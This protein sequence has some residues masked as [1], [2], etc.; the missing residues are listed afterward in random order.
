MKT[1]GKIIFWFLIFI[2]LIQFIPVDRENKP[3]KKSE[4]FVDVFHTPPKVLQ[5][6]KNACYDCHSNE[7]VYPYYAFIAPISW[8]IKHHINEGRERLN[9]SVWTT[10]NADL[11]KNMLVNSADVLQ[12]KLMPMPGY[13]AY[14]PKANL[15]NAQRTVLINYFNKIL[16][17]KKY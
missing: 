16:E 12:N 14:H 15:T 6:L 13:I 17:S 3:V 5:L 11:K 9:F 1:F 4:N 10:F 7:T 2:S 8:G